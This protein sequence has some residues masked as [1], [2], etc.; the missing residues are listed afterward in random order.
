MTAG[1]SKK[2]ELQ[3]VGLSDGHA[4]AVIE[5]HE[6]KGERV[7]RLR[8]QILMESANLMGIGVTPAP[9]GPKI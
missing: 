8:N 2:K 1:S 6:I 3:E 5:V 4:F 7:M 9:N